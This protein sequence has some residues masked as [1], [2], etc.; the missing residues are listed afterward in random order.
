MRRPRRAATNVERKHAWEASWHT[1]RGVSPR[2]NAV[3]LIR[4]PIMPKRGRSD[5]HS[6]CLPVVV[7]H[8]C[9]GALCLYA[10]PARRLL[11]PRGQ[12]TSCASA[13][14][15]CHIL[16]VTPAAPPHGAP[17]G[18]RE[19]ELG[20]RAPRR[21]EVQ[22]VSEV[23][24]ARIPHGERG[25]IQRHSI[26]RST[27]VWSKSTLETSARR[28]NGE[29]RRHGTRKPGAHPCAQQPG[30]RPESS[31][32]PGGH[33]IEEAAPLVI[34]NDEDRA[35]PRRTPGEDRVDEGEERLAVADVGIGVVVARR[36]TGIV[37][38]ARFDEG[39]WGSWPAGH[40]PG[41]PQTG[42]TAERYDVPH[43]AKN[44]A[45]LK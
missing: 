38:E 34:G 40:P 23:V 11:H 31:T 21:A 13:R 14:S 32:L 7:R 36:A 33:M 4:H 6:A 3:G 9:R 45:S 19:P 29:M 16:V 24:R 17:N 20:G 2:R 43:R 1:T 15:W 5:T 35:P 37:E 25:K 12:P 30:R 44:G 8:P 28:A 18:R 42:E 10:C 27:E 22:R 26:R 41:T 39:H